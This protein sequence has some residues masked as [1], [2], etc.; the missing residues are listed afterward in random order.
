L[1]LTVACVLRSGGPYHAA[2]VK[3]IAAQV[4]HWLPDAR[5]VC[6]SDV[7]VPCERVR[8]E[9]GWPGWWSKIELFDHFKGRT[10][11]LDIDTV[12]INGPAHLVTGAFTMIRNWV[13]TDLTASG[14]M[15]WEGDYS[16]IARAFEKDTE[17]VMSQY[18]TREQWGDQAFITEHAGEVQ[19]FPDGEIA[20]YKFNRL[21]LQP[22]RGSI[23]AFNNNCLPWKG[24][25]WA[26]K[27][28]A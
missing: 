25:D 21:R 18:V 20:S 19:R 4:A 11:F 3:G 16:H 24:P 17:R 9:S 28:W 1:E 15:S 27:W 22:R 7:P 2:H 13:Y 12:I 10:L 5:M 8:M 23:V 26:K 6:L 14:V